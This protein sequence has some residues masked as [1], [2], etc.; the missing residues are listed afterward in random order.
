MACFFSANVFGCAW[1]S[2]RLYG[3]LAEKTAGAAVAAA[4]GAIGKAVKEE[5]EKKVFWMRDPKSG[6][7][8]PESHFD[9]VD[10][11]ELR[12]KLLAKKEG[13]L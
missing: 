11:A 8:I 4:G 13:K 1:F 3:A 9:V 5:E 7:W 2:R 6:N 12:E 10:V